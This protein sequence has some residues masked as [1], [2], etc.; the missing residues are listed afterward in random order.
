MT[1]EQAYINFTYF[2]DGWVG[3]AVDMPGTFNT[4]STWPIVGA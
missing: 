1:H 2:F 3:L 4:G